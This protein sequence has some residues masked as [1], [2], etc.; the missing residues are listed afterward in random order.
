MPSVLIAAA[1]PLDQDRLRL[2]AEIREIKAA[3]QRSRHRDKWEIESNQAATV[4]DLRR[5][6]LDLRPA[7][8][9]FAGHGHGPGGL[10]FENTRGN[11]HS[12]DAKPLAKLFHHFKDSLKCVVLNACY[13]DEQ[14]EVIR[15]EID[16]VIGMRAAVDDDAAIGFSVA[17]YDALFAGTDFRTAFDLA[18]TALDLKKMPDSDVPIFMTSPH[19]E[20]ISLPY[21]SHIPEIER[22]LYAYINTPFAE[23]WQFTTTGKTISQQMVQHYGE[24]MHQAVEKVQVLS[25]A[26]LTPDQWRVSV[27]VS[28]GGNQ[29]QKLFYMKISDYSVLVEWEATVGLWSVPVKTYLALDSAEPVIARVF[30]E[31]A[32]VYAGLEDKELFQSVSLSTLEHTRLVGY[33]RRGT[34]LHGELLAVLADGN[35]HS[36]TVEIVKNGSTSVIKK[37]LTTT[38]LYRAPAEGT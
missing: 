19:L 32:I 30:A 28:L 8:V 11:T 25:M 5:A 34:P 14:A 20:G 27:Q 12:A 4:D 37:L 1:S 6:V 26:P 10:C 13:S 15:Q 3:L 18:C 23:R 9:H 36:L 38:W 16:N 7:V 35:E 22:I 21:S 29:L 2:G 17:F 24:V 33:V 31:L